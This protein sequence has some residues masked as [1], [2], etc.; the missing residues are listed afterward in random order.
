MSVATPT[1]TAGAAPKRRTQGG[2]VIRFIEQHC[3]IPDGDLIGQPFKVHPWWRARINEIFELQPQVCALCGEVTSY[4]E[5]GPDDGYVCAVCTQVLESVPPEARRYSEV[6]IGIAKKNI[7][8]SIMAALGLYFMIADGDP[9]ALVISAAA[10]EEQGANLLY[11]S[12]KIMCE[13]SPTLQQ[14]TEP[15]DKEIIVPSLP[16]ARMRNVASKAGTQDGQ[17]IKVL[18]AD[19]LH[20]WLGTR[21]RNL[22]T[23]LSGGTGAR[24]N[25][26]RLA[27]TTAGFDQ[28]SLCYEKY[29]Y[30]KKVN[31]GEIDDPGFYCF[32]LEA[33]EDSD[34]R[35]PKVWAMT[36]PL[37]GVSV[38]ESYIRDRVKRDPESV[39][40]RYNTNMWVSGE[41]IWVPNG[42][43]DKCFSPLDLDPKLP[44]GVGID[45][46][47]NIDS[48][49]LGIAQRHEM[50]PI[51]PRCGELATFT[52]QGPG[53]GY[54]CSVCSEDLEE[55]P[56]EVRYVLNGTIWENP[57]PEHHSL[58]ADWRMNNNLVMDEC[59]RLFADFPVPSCEIDGEIKPGPAYGFDPWR[60]RTEAST[61]AGEGLAMI[62]FPQN[63]ARMIPVSQSFFEAILK[64]VIAQN[65][66]PKFKRHVHNVTADQKPRGWRMSKPN[67]SKRKIDWA[68]AAGIA[69]FL[70]EFSKAVPTTSAYEDHDLIV[71]GG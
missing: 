10:S 43:W 12:A 68:I 2:R 37:L 52:E 65:G 31:A 35:D 56:P 36:N 66:D 30:G 19:E 6:L 20:E 13:K 61:L 48:S 41:E 63:D 33:P 46:A 53:D 8:T 58:H 18:L 51:C 34:Y 4:T 9:S 24:F 64:G 59:R 44:T 21:G 28:D 3:V 54:V 50:P 47:K 7:K 70:A 17:N 55:P 11:G 71:V 62:E 60:F 15:Y 29:E 14:L 42:A 1:R 45:I 40:R 25:A 5:R 22:W 27:I 16:R 57:Y 69:R 32:W 39:V 49:A 38:L 67:G 23:V 26:M